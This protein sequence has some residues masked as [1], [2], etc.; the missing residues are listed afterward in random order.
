MPFTSLYLYYFV[1][2]RS[3]KNNLLWAKYCL[4]IFNI[5]I[6]SIFVMLNIGW[7]SLDNRLRVFDCTLQ[8]LLYSVILTFNDPYILYW[9][10]IMAKS[11]FCAFVLLL[12]Y[13]HYNCWVCRCC[14]PSN[15]FSIT[16][17]LEKLLDSLE[18]M[19]TRFFMKNTYILS[20]NKRVIIF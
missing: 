18:G 19:K 11:K 16:H 1:V 2:E 10:M 9:Y 12:S 7:Y 14:I 5:D 4:L 20:F 6:L 8:Q 13:L 15:N 3:E 17:W